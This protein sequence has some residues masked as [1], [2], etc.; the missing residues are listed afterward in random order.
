MAGVLVKRN[1]DLKTQKR[2]TWRR[3]HED[4]DRGWSLLLLTKNSSDWQEPLE[5]G[6]GKDGRFPEA[7]G[8]A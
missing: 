1:R 6:G 3:S 4:R 2:Q 5:A 8:G 7:S